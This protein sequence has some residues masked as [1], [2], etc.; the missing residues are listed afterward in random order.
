MAIAFFDLDRTLISRNS[1][2]MWV[3]SELRGGHITYGQALAAYRWIARYHL[4]FARLEDALLASI[5]SLRGAVEAPVRERTLAFY[6]RE[7]RGLFRPGAFA[8]I[9]RHRAA[10]DA[11]VLLTSSSSYLAAAACADL[12]FDGYLCNRFEVD[13]AGRYSGRPVGPLCYGPGKVQAALPFAKERGVP[14]VAC[15]F[16]SDSASDLPMLNAVGLPVAVNPDPRLRLVA[17]ARGW[18]IVDWGEPEGRTVEPD[19]ATAAV[20]SRE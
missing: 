6:E 7:V 20:P 13:A 18:K 14:L 12:G 16:Y 19:D 4:G 9:A 17:L 15:A 8:T 5:A 11:L 3:R 1:G 10:G 2:A